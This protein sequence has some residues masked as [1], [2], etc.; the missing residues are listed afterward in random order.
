MLKLEG[1]NIKK[2]Y[3]DRLILDIKDLKIYSNDRIGIVGLNGSGKTTL[4][5]ILS[6][7]KNPDEGVVKIYGN[8]SYI[9]QLENPLNAQLNPKIGSLFNINNIKDTGSLSGGEKTK[10]K[11]AQNI[12]NSSDIL[13]ADEPTSNL[14]MKSIKIL[15][16]I[17]KTFDGCLILISHDRHLLDSLCNKILEIENGKVKEYKGNY[18]DYIHQKKMEIERQKLEYER[19]SKE[20]QRL[21]K[22]IYDVKNKANSMKKAPSRMGISEA[23]LHKGFTSGKKAKIH[24]TTNSLKTRIEKLERKEKPKESAKT[25][26]DIPS[27]SKLRSKVVIRGSK[28][29][30]S[31]DN[32]V[33]FKDIDLE[34]K[35]G[36][37][38]ALIG[39]NGTGKTTL[40]NMI[41]FG[42]ENIKIA[43]KVKIA[44]FSQELE[45]LDERDTIIESV[46]KNSIYNETF[47]RTLLARLLFK[48]DDVYKTIKIISGGEKVKT[49]FAK[50]FL[51]DMNLVILDEPTNY[52]DIH[53]IESL[54]DVLKDY[55]GTLF[56][57]SHDRRFIDK[58]TNKLFILENKSLVVYDGNYSSY[59]NNKRNKIDKNNKENHRRLLIL[60]NKLSEIN[61]RLSMP[62]KDEDIEALE[63]EF[64]IIIKEI[65]SLKN[66]NLN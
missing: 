33:L 52:L 37:K 63:R 16:E 4:M 55:T 51:Q 5:D 60:Q 31:F 23:R 57:T 62:S 59:L 26:I 27:V 8:H 13:F 18:S 49:A 22:A 43:P 14:D 29:S 35:N 39:D 9:T 66:I 28:I 11:I 36:D 21:E 44:Y 47:V 10:L 64:N 1:L 54:E 2:Y 34:I 17:L 24:Q 65:N 7:S 15:E 53:S 61:S 48:R 32:K 40:I 30:K 3:G 12:D 19:F 38:I 50:I 56:I 45:I 6:K 46:M 20:K 41:V 25:Q 42:S 58:V